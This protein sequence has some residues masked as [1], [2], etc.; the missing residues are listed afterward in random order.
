[1][2]AHQILVK[3]VVPVITLKILLYVDVYPLGQAQHVL[4]PLL[5]LQLLVCFVML[6]ES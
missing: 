2:H 6:N 1:M 5:Q 4:F 3:M